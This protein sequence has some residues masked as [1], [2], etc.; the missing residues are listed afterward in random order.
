MN[1]V[2][3]LWPNIRKFVIIMRTNV[4]AVNESLPVPD[5]TST[6]CNIPL[7]ASTYDL[8]VHVQ[9]AVL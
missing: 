3:I 5:P 4:I 1:V 9:L 8:E 7:K 6:G 2:H